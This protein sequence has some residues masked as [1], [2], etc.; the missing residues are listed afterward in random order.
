[1]VG[2]DKICLSGTTNTMFYEAGL[3]MRAR[4]MDAFATPV[5]HTVQRTL[6]KEI[7]E[8]SREVAA[9]QITI[10]ACFSPSCKKAE[11]KQGCRSVIPPRGGGIEQILHIQEAQVV[12][13]S[14]ADDD[15]LSQCCFIG[16][17]AMK[18]LLDLPL[19]M[20]RV[21]ADPDGSIILLSPQACGRNI[22]KGFP[23]ACSSFSKYDIGRS[24]RFPGLESRSGNGRKVS[25]S[26]ACFCI[27]AKD[28]A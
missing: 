7:T 11:G 2:Y 15:L 3:V 9:H 24:E 12:L 27:L 14:F 17:E 20:S 5:C 13:T 6:A 18:F 16:I 25:L 22:A 28:L 4:S 10:A 21:S 26:G 19:K 23:R 8:P 1:M